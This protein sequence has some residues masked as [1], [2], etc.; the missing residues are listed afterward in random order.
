[1]TSERLQ[2]R[3]DQV[4]ANVD[5]VDVVGRAGVQLGR[6]N[7]PRGKCPF[8]GSTSPSFMVD[9]GRRYAR[10]WGCDW[11][12]DVIKFTM[13]SF[14]LSFVE[15]ID[16]LEDENGL[17]G[18]ASA[19]VR[20]EKRQRRAPDRQLV[21]STTMGRWIWKTAAPRPDA[22]RTYLLAR[23]V[24]ASML[25][26]DRLGDIRFHALAPLFPWPEDRASPAP[27]ALKAPAICALIREPVIVD[28][29]VAFRPTGLHVTYLSPSL[30]SKMVRRDSCGELIEQRKMLGRALG[31]CV[32]LGRTRALDDR[33]SVA[34]MP[35]VPLFPGEGIETVLSGMAIAGATAHAVGLATLSLN[36][37]QG[38]PVRWKNGVLPLYDIR[39]DAEAQF[40]ALSFP[41][42]GP[43]TGLVDA[44]MKPL[45]GPRDRRT[46]E[47]LG[48]PVVE[49]RGGPV[50]R[51]AI[52]TA[53]RAEICAE[54]LVKSWRAAGCR[55]VAAVRPHMGLD[56]NDA[57]REAR[58]G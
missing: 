25:A 41:H 52:T 6:G 11:H 10:C 29:A 18:V 4:R 39:P 16:R 35:D 51:R 38:S 46:G 13:D 54:L 55:R 34:I 45:R 15:A 17:D 9:V 43:V 50:V 56:F 44:D 40:R 49:T 24:P 19:P 53:E 28:G 5:Y 33:R 48:L 37:L 26:D 47:R 2:Q 20:T 32:I 30:D 1:M 14:G 36:N 42:W 22:V 27:E 8:H 58:N 12:G 31:G 3:V 23:G 7:K 21:D 57:A